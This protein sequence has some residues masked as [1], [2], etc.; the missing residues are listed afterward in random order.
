MTILK[1]LLCQGWIGYTETKN[2][3]LKKSFS[4]DKEASCS[5]NKIQGHEWTEFIMSCVHSQNPDNFA[6]PI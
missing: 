1:R 6:L 3:K 5:E 4:A 2:L